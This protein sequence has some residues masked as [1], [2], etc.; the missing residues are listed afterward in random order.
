MDLR[1]EILKAH[2]K[3]QAIKIADYVSDNTNLFKALVNLYLCGPYRITQRCAWPINICVERHPKLLSP[4]L[5]GILHQLTR[6]EIHDAAKRNTLRMLQFVSIPK[7]FHAKVIDLCFAFLQS[8]EEPVAVKVFSMSVLFKVVQDKPELLR[9]LAIILED[10]L[11]YSS[12]GYR[13][14]ATKI[15]KATPTLTLS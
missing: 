2:S 11:P 13:S 3:K 6:L 9:E 5:K 8:K 1:A 10:Q 7:Q 14:R 4:H 15:L 12:A